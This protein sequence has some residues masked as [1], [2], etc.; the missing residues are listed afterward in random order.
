MLGFEE[1]ITVYNQYYDMEQDCDRY[2]ATVVQGC[3]W[4][5]SHATGMGEK[6]FVRENIYQIRIPQN[7]KSNKVLVPA[8]EFVD[9][10]TQYTLKAG[11]KI[12]KGKADIVMEKGDDLEGKYAEICTILI[13]HDNDRGLLNHTYVE[14]H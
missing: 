9:P 8:I 4:A 6:S 13:I 11:D 10:K 2:S 5:S 7:A 14:G 1:T 3:S 12:V